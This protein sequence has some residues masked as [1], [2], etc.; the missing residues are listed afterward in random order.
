[1][2]ISAPSSDPLVS[3]TDAK[4]KIREELCDRMAE[5]MG[6]KWHLS[7][8]VEMVKIN[9]EGE[10]VIIETNFR[11]E[12]ETLLVMVDFD[13]QFNDQ[14]DLIMR[15]I[16]EFI[17]NG[18]GW[19]VSQVKNIVMH[20]V[21]YRPTSGSSYIKTPNQIARKQAIINVQNEDNLCFVWSILAALHPQKDNAHRVSKYI[22]YQ[23][24]LNIKDLSFPLG[25]DQ[26]KKFERLNSSISVNVFAL[27][28]KS[29][30]YP[31]Y[32][33]S[34][35]ERKHVNL[36]LLT[37][38]DK[39]HYAW[40]KDM[41]SLLSQSGYNHA[42]HYCNYCLHG[43][44]KQS[45]LDRHVEDCSKI[46]AQKVV[47]PDEDDRWVQF[48]SI[49]KML[50]VPFVIYAD[51]ESYTCKIQGPL[52]VGQATHAYELHEPSGFAYYIVCA[53]SNRQYKPVVYR[54]QNVVE[55]FL[56]SLRKE[57]DAICEIIKKAAPMRI[58]TAEEF[59]FQTAER[60]YLC[61]ELLGTDR[62]RDHDHL[63][64]RFRGPAHSNCNLQLQYD[65][66]D[67]KKSKFFIPVIF[68]N[69]RGYDSHLILKGYKKSIFGKDNMSCIPNNT[70]RY[71]SFTI[72]NLRF[73]D[74]CQFLN[75]SLDSL[76]TN[77][78]E[79]DFVHSRRHTPIEKFHLITRK[80]VFCYDYWDGPD[81]ASESSLPPPEA[82]YSRLKEEGIT[83]E[84]YRHAQRVWT[85]FQLQTLGDYHD[86]YLKTD[87]LVLADVFET[88]RSTCL[89]Q[90]RLD[91]CHYFS[92]P[93]LS[94]DAMLKMTNVKLE[95]MTDRSMHDIID[96]GIKGGMCCISHKHAVANNRHM[97][98]TFDAA[99]PSSYIL[100]L[101]MNNLYGT[102]M[103]QALPE[104]EFAFLPEERLQ[105]FDFMSVPDEG[106][107][108]YILE[109]DIEYPDEL[110]DEHNDYPL[111]PESIV[112]DENE[113]SPYTHE[114]AEKLGIK[115]SGCRKLV[116]N[117]KSKQ[118]YSVHYRNLKQYVN[119]GMRVTKIHRIISFT[120]SKWLKP[121]IDFN[122]ERRKAAKNDFEKDFFKLMNNAVFGK[123]MEN[124][125]KHQNV[126]LVN[127]GRRLRRLTSKP[128]FKSCKIFSEDLVGVHMSKTEVRLVKPTYVG[129]SILDLSKMFMFAF[130][131]EKMRPKY[132]DRAK[133]LMTDT[134]SL[135]Y[136]IQTDDVFVDMMED[137]DS[138]DT[139]DYPRDHP[140]YS[141]KNKKMLGKMKDEYN[142][143]IIAEFV[144]LRPKMYSIL[145]TDGHEKRKAKGVN[146]CTRDKA[147]THKSYVQTLFDE[148][149]EYVTMR[150][151]RSHNHD[152]FTS[153]MNKIGLSP[154]DDKRYVL[155]DRV[156]TF[157]FG[158]RRI[159]Q[160]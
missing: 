125:R 6:V 116:A 18:S 134:D 71:L 126:E 13:E 129:M 90:Y 42:K 147:L 80:G 52:N 137:L 140:A 54:G 5:H 132:G 11:G 29:G 81:K 3:L 86:L 135:V 15:R 159:L 150:Q 160:Q 152:V 92:S 97:G 69:L 10:E 22:H 144:G 38:D 36:I 130:H 151:I 62:V 82:F 61:D 65:N 14:V 58:T 124:L 59:T 67:R 2:S 118:R 50:K 41:S 70:E 122:T 136:F 48:K 16:K 101:D 128:N 66:A 76:A 40:I 30:V 56:K 4:D 75:A 102:S 110:H 25:I 68:H 64:G 28:K 72:D 111:C 120:Q 79:N 106:P 156:S 87:T 39:S 117:L 113:L 142:G 141:D 112:I 73:I 24:E 44:L 153:E 83:D 154:Y 133:L 96:K 74:S 145:E 143:R 103:V 89:Q 108:G 94:W 27:D 49:Q 19:T 46:G 84:E 95:L 109:V 77:L 99:K 57:S 88:F 7:I 60:C 55:M 43:F 35:K 53:D 139:S 37:D 51:F 158:H 114:L 9:R 23:S 20:S 1:M 12:T 148:R 31:V 149:I 85:E 34:F 32:I 131:Y 107:V 93:G 26:V 21:I 157:A 119:L 100:Y 104:K 105:S 8:T 123:T 17:G 63:T 91:A 127:D 78:K 47:L 33:T 121:Y 138:Y 146:R 155:A 45:T 115:S 98:E